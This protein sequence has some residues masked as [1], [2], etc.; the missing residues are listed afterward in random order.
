[1]VVIDNGGRYVNTIPAREPSTQAEIRIVSIGKESLIE[2]ADHVQHLTAVQGR[3]RVGKEDFFAAFELAVIRLSGSAP[4]I[5]TIGINEMAHFVDL[6]AV[7]MEQDFACTHAYR[8]TGV[9]AANEFIKPGRV[10]LGIIV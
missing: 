8:R 3:G 1:M 9:H 6:F 10:G 2:Y 4:V 7:A 5:Q